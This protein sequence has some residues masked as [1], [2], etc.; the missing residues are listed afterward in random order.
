[1]QRWPAAAEVLE[2]AGRWAALQRSGHPDLLAVGVFGS[3]GRGTAGVG[4]D[5]DL[6]LIL[7]RCDEPIWDRLRRWDTGSLPLAC[8]LLV[9]SLEEWRNLPRWNLKLAEALLRDTRWLGGIPE[10][11]GQQPEPPVA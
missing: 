3:Y 2:Q 7:Q 1:M 5:L 9:Y 10:P 11:P 8:D 4:S 6:L